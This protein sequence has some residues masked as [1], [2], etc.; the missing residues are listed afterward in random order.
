MARSK[1]APPCQLAYTPSPHAPWLRR[2]QPPPPFQ[3][4]ALL[5]L[6][7]LSPRRLTGPAANSSSCL[8]YARI[9]FLFLPAGCKLR[10]R[11]EPPPSVSLSLSSSSPSHISLT[12]GSPWNPLKGRPPGGGYTGHSLP[13]L[14]TGKCP[15]NQDA[16]C[17][18]PR[19]TWVSFNKELH[20]L[21]KLN[22]DL[23]LWRDERASLEPF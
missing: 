9:H 11:R 23:S 8:N 22:L 3:A 16:P 12:Q 18:K 19:R 4:T 10:N 20:T 17:Q 2:A 7:N 21:L 15:E 5:P 13:S 14:N 6:F 1:A